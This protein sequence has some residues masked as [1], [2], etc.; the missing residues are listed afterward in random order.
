[1]NVDDFAKI[2]LVIAVS[3]S[4]LG[5][6]YQT[7]RLIGSTAD[8]IKDLRKVLQNFGTLSD[9]FIVDYTYITDKLK[10]IVDTVGGF[11]TNIVDPLKTIFSFVGKFKRGK[12]SKDEFEYEDDKEV[13]IES[14]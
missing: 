5:I 14:E 7:M 2:L 3:I 9:K 11:A 8:S 6:S 12:K 10:N 1:M 13:E 4:L